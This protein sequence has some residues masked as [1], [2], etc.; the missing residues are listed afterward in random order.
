MFSNNDAS[1][2]PGR[3]ARSPRTGCNERGARVDGGGAH[4]AGAAVRA[5]KAKLKE[6]AYT[7]RDTF[8]DTAAAPCDTG[9]TGDGHRVVAET[10]NTQQCD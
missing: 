8:D 10:H 6:G 7:A 3:A 9:D 4:A 1:R 2:P 5:R